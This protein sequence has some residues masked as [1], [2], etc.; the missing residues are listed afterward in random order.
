MS[1]KRAIIVGAGSYGEVFSA[2][3][4]EFY[5]LVGFVD[6]DEKKSGWVINNIPV[7]GTFESLLNDEV[8]IAF[9]VVFCAIG[10]NKV[11]VNYLS[12][13]DLLGF[14]IPNFI[15]PSV[16]ICDTTSLGDAVYILPNA[17]IMPMSSIGNYCIVS[18][19]STIA[20]HTHLKQ[21]VFISSGVAIG[22]YLTIEENATIGI[23]ATIK[24]GS[25]SIGKNALVGAGSNV[26]ND[27]DQHSVVAGNPAKE[28]YKSEKAAA[29]LTNKRIDI[30]K[31]KIKNPEK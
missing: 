29:K 27:V 4:K 3:L 26:L 19:G 30:L 12:S 15:H 8:T 13:L 7:I 16:H 14:K 2:Y 21:G 1:K 10:N 20:H 6:D 5:E 28:L 22:S 31:E 25:F 11:R 18:V 23:G 9:D 17:T 24:S